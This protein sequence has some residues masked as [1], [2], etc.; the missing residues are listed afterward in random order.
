VVE[1]VTETVITLLLLLPPQPARTSSAAPATPSSTDEY[2]FCDFVNKRAPK[3][4]VRPRLRP[5]EV[6][7]IKSGNRRVPQNL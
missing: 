2:N 7:E 5:N 6:S 1:G 3:I 4:L